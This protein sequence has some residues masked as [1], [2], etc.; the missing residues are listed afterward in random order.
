MFFFLKA[1]LFISIVIVIFLIGLIILGEYL[2]GKFKDSKFAKWWK[3]NVI[4]EMPEITE[5]HNIRTGESLS[6]PE[7]SLGI[8]P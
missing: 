2:T 1:F 5:M 4:T 8:N 7:I 3:K 6:P